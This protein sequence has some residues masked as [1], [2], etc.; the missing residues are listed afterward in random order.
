[1]RRIPAFLHILAALLCVVVLG[2]YWSLFL[3]YTRGPY[4]RVGPILYDIINL[5]IGSFIGVP[6]LIFSILRAVQV[7][8][9]TEGKLGRWVSLRGISNTFAILGLALLGF[10]LVFYTPWKGIFETDWPEAHAE[11]REKAA[12]QKARENQPKP[13]PELTD[14][15]LDYPKLPLEPPDYYAWT[16]TTLD[17]QDIPMTELKGKVFFLNFWATWCPPCR[18]EMP[19]I[20]RLYN[21]MKDNPSLAFA[22]VTKDESETI[23]AFLDENEYTLPIYIVKDNPPRAITPDAIPTTYILTP[24]GKIAYEHTG[25]AAWDTNKTKNFLTALATKPEAAPLQ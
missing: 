19:N 23:N 21:T 15:S 9:S 20:Q 22:F 16:V 12:A 8:G 13:K 25:A 3:L 14:A 2:F 7:F 1:M 10:I 4:V 18:E 5:T 6:V 11:A 17:G 24:D